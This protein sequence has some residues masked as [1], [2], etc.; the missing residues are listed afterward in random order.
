MS[1]AGNCALLAVEE[2]SVSFRARGAAR[3]VVSEAVRRA[4]FQL[5]AG[6][7]LA[8]VGE[9]G[10]GKSVTAL[11]LLQLLP[12]PQAFHPCGSIRYRGRELIGAGDAV[13]R[14]I[15]GNDISMIFQEP[16]SALNPLHRIEK[17]IS[18]SLALHQG[19]RPAAARARACELLNQ[20][21]MEAELHIDSYPHQLSGGQRQRVMIAM[22]LANK[23]EILIADEPTTALDVT[24]QARILAL[25][26]ELKESENLSLLLITHDLSMVRK[27][28]ERVLVMQ[29]G[30]IVER[31]T[32]AQI[33]TAPA[34]AYTRQLLEAEPQPRAP[35]PPPPPG[36]RALLAVEELKVWFPIRRG[37][38]K[39]TAGHI[40]AVNRVS[41]TLY[42]GRNL[43]IVGESGCGKT[44]L[45]LAALRL[46]RS[47]GGVT[48]DGE[49]LARL[50]RRAMK[51]ARR[52]MQIVF[53]DPFGSLSPRMPVLDIVSEGL[54]AH[55]LMPDA[56]VAERRVIEIL[57]EVEI[58]PDMRNRYPHEFSGG[59]RQRIAIARALIL[60]PKVLFLDEPTSAL[61]RSVQI[62]VLG[63]LARIQRQR[64]LAYVFISHDLSVVRAIADELMVMRAGEVVEQGAAAEI[65]AAPK[66]PYTRELLRA[67]F[68][69]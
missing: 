36:A 21:G 29:H 63:L 9:S 16:M 35:S 42:P 54:N 48:F 46:L 28:A 15:R 19:L 64:R 20:A 1:T 55:R 26:K 44:T 31:G 56:A 6:E 53:Q 68:G 8:L 37:L 11:S 65:F 51:N 38:L 67:A 12:Y 18:E 30:R 60:E 40:K 33:F 58:D 39:R 10:S 50:P 45:A 24:V 2:L 32:R 49:S 69:E 34:H 4:S 25:L 57:R 66:H 41:F 47:Q 59:Q 17:Q 3:E 13:H 52:E 23:P 27:T 43:G 61:D 62:Q 14:S 7:T 22:A 5:H